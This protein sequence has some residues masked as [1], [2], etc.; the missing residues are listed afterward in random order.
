MDGMIQL[1]AQYLET[2]EKRSMGFRM[3][4]WDNKLIK[5][6]KFFESEMMDLSVNIPLEKALDKG[7]EILAQC[8][9]PEET[10]LRSDLIN[11]FW[12][13]NQKSEAEKGKE[14]ETKKSSEQK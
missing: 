7:W 8:F 2:E 1:Y 6:G 10:N 11:K 13:D 14:S 4:E 3:S 12:P 9:K 5:Y